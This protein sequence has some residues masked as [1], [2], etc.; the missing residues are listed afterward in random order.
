MTA[1]F[2]STTTQSLAEL[3]FVKNVLDS[4]YCSHYTLF[5][6]DRETEDIE[7]EKVRRGCGVCRRGGAAGL[8]VRAQAGARQRHGSSGRAH[9][10]LLHCRRVTFCAR[11][12]TRRVCGLWLHASFAVAGGQTVAS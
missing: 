2:F 7:A 8:A 12:Q 6:Y 4:N 11:R 1:N 10:A 3:S 5:S 9:G